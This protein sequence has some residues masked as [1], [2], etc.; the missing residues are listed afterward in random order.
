MEHPK[1]CRELKPDCPHINIIMK[2]H[3][4]KTV[5]CTHR[6]NVL[7]FTIKK[8]PRSI[9]FE[10]DTILPLWDCPFWVQARKDGKYSKVQSTIN[11][12]GK[13]E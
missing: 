9:R 2:G 3:A 5:T 11:E 1:D 4:I 7:D 10:V 8:I 6:N 12:N 13:Y